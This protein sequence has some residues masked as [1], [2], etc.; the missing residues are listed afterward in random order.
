MRRQVVASPAEHAA[1]SFGNPLAE[2]FDV[3][4]EVVNLQLLADDDLVQLVQQVFIEAGLDFQLG[5]AVVGGVGGVHCRIGYEL[6]SGRPI[7]GR[8]ARA[9]PNSQPCA[10]SATFA[11][12]HAIKRASSMNPKFYLP[13]IGTT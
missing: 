8:P 5:Q 9:V 7:R 10:Y 13:I 3:A 6:R 11:L 4:Y 12:V 2:R 1:A